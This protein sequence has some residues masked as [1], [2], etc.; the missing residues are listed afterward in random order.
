[1]HDNNHVLY[2]IVM[3]PY[4]IATIMIHWSLI[5]CHVVITVCIL[6]VESCCH[7]TEFH[8]CAIIHSAIIHSYPHKL[9][10]IRCLPQMTY[11]I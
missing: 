10:L 5:C 8:M 1:M 4:R 9:A 7:I 6:G 2:G 11:N 3:V